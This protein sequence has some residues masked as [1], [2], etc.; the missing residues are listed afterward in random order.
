V[1]VALWVSPGAR[2]SELAGQADGRLRV[3]VAA[4]AH[5]GK[6]NVELVRLLAE[7][8]AVPRSQVRI[9]G[10][11]TGRRKRVH[12]Q[13]ITVDEARRRFRLQED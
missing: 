9:T 5:E 1:S 3:R 13:G 2:R 6:A 7:V 12:I 8:L 10:G 11:A 4:P